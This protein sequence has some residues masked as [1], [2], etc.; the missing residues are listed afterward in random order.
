LYWTAFDKIRQLPPIKTLEDNDQFCTFLKGLLDEHLPVIP[1]L[2]LGLSISSPN[3]SPNKLDPFMRRM[4][5]SRIS[6]RVLV[7]HHIALSDTFA[8]KDDNLNR[9]HVGI[10][11]TDL[12]VKDSIDRC[13]AV[14]NS[15]PPVL[16]E[17]PEG[18]K[19]PGVVVDGD[20]TTKFPYIKEHLDYVIYELLHNAMLSTSLQQRREGNA[21]EAPT[22][23]ATIV[24][25]SDEIQLRISDQGGG[26]LRTCISEP[27]D[28]YSFSHVRNTSRL[29]GDRINALQHASERTGIKGTVQEKLAK[30]EEQDLPKEPALRPP[31]Q[32]GL[33]LPMSNIFATYFG[34]SLDLV[35]LD[36]YG[37]DV[38]LRLPKLGT[39]LEGVEL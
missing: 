21:S 8:G 31:R 6:R 37:M 24:A 12:N 5:V 29:E 3:L 14:L 9:D 1:N 18:L 38:Y 16:P 17:F 19:W 27:S 33:G 26:L 36:G 22:V 32:F 7:E 34:G 28:L 11:Y 4:L 39:S 30:F 13:L 2:S 10:I 35:S 23:F 20:V 25:G 15:Q